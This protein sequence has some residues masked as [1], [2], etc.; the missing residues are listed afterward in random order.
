MK[1]RFELTDF[2]SIKTPD[3]TISELVYRFRA[4]RKEMKLSREALAK[5]SK[6]SFA[7]LRRFEET[8]EISLTSLVKLANAMGML[9]DFDKLFVTPKVKSIKDL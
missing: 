4:R 1:N 8:G 2:V 3:S 6:V 5:E 9:D 7:S